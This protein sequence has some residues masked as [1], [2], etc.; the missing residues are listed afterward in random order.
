M[1]APNARPRGLDDLLKDQDLAAH[2]EDMRRGFFEELAKQNL[3][4]ANATRA[5]IDALREELRQLR[6]A[7]VPADSPIATG[8]G[9]LAQFTRLTEGR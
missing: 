8:P 3:R 1:P 6:A 5:D 7:L 4:T 9:V 2:R